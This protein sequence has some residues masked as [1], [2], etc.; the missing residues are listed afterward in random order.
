MIL[1]GLCLYFATDLY[2]YSKSPVDPSGT[3]K[4]VITVNAG[5]RFNSLVDELSRHHLINFPYK[6]KLI[7]RL[8]KYD[9]KIMA[10]E[11]ELSA[12]MSP[13]AILETLISGKIRLHRLAVPEGFNI[14][15]IAQRVENF[16]FCGQE[17]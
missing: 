15:Q 10:G 2:H 1:A 6:F 12:S 4:A 13:L 9:R 8:K 7:A 14:K 11:Y 16:G 3:Q 5:Q 17:D